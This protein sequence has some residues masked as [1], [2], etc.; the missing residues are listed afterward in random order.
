VASNLIT[1]TVV[2]SGSTVPTVVLTM[3]STSFT[4]SSPATATVQVSCDS[5]CGQAD[6]RVDGAEW[7]TV[8]LNSSGSFTTSG[9]PGGV[10]SHTLVVNYLGNATY[11]AT[12]SNTINYVVTG[13]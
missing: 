9:V 2:S 6:F 4:E 1:Y 7:A 8:P 12:P 11:A 3:T 5:A 10:G 13:P